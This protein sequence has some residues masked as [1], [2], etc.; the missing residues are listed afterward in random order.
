[1]IRNL[2]KSPLDLGMRHLTVILLLCCWI[3]MLT[4]TV[5]CWVSLLIKLTLYVKVGCSVL[6]D[7]HSVVLGHRGGLSLVDSI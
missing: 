5:D 6:T 3:G 1:M 2:G 4:N 7:G